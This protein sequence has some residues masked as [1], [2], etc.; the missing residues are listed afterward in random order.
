M[1]GYGMVIAP[2]NVQLL[3]HLADIEELH[4]LC[5]VGPFPRPYASESYVHWTAPSDGNKSLYL[6]FVGVVFL[7]IL[8]CF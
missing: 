6:V 8:D 4:L 7:S 1:P 3:Y 5:L 2:L